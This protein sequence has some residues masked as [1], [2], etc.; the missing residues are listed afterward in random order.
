MFLSVY[1]P[2][3]SAENSNKDAKEKI[4]VLIRGKE[5]AFPFPEGRIAQLFEITTK[6]D[7]AETRLSLKMTAQ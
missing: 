1:F 3:F 6:E 5:P 4:S 7:Q 2:K